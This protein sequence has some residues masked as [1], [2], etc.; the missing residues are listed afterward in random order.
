VVGT[1]AAL[2]SRRRGEVTISRM[3]EEDQIVAVDP[4]TRADGV[5]ATML[6][7]NQAFVDAVQADREPPIPGWEGRRNVEVVLAAHQASREGRTIE[8]GD[9]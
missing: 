2:V 8:L 5:N 9:P 1:R 3:G 7:E 6:A 4:V